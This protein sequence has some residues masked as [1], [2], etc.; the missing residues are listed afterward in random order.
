MEPGWGHGSR[1]LGI[2]PMAP[3]GGFCWSVLT[4]VLWGG[5]LYLE[6]DFDPARALRLLVD[7]KITVFSAP[8]VFFEQF[9]MLPEFDEADLSS[10]KTAS[11]GGSPVPVALLRRWQERGVL[12][13][14]VYGLTEAG[15]PIQVTSVADAVDHPD[16][17]GRRGLHR[18][19]RIVRPD[20]SDCDPNEP[21]E[22]IVGGAAV[23]PGYWNAEETTREAFRDGWLYTGDLGEFDE[24]GFLKITG[25]LK[26]MIISGGFNIGPAEI[27]HVIG[28]P[29]PKFGETPAAVV[30]ASAPLEV[31][32]I[33]EFCNARL[34]DYKVPRYVIVSE[35]PLPRNQSGKVVKPDIRNQYPDIPGTF[36]R[37]R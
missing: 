6:P 13:R 22:V 32:R 15:G 29:D 8:V 3:F 14:Q 18:K 10:L 25:R 11:L 17:C 5:T 1:L 26:D 23:S 37:V 12:L 24:Q 4:Q 28:V 33:V 19:V 31:E 27:E 21:G 7:K 20:G 35:Q 9:A 36:P 30:V 2:A 16:R 34:A